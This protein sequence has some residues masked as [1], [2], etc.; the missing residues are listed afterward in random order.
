VVRLHP[1]DRDERVAALGER[2]GEQVF[3]LARLVAAEG[4][5]RADVVSLRPQRGAAE[6]L[7]QPLER[8]DGRRPE[9]QRVAVE[10]FERGRHWP[11]VCR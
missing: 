11:S 3:E 4:K 7:S 6:V 1:A 10:S 2:V 9:Q 8:M 5:T